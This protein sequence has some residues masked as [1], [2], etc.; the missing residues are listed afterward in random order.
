[1][2][3]GIVNLPDSRVYSGR[4]TGAKSVTVCSGT[5]SI[6]RKYERFLKLTKFLSGTSAVRVTVHFLVSFHGGLWQRQRDR[7]EVAYRLL[8]LGTPAAT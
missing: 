2:L 8:A 1:M 3:S 4:A 5:G 6:C 7:P